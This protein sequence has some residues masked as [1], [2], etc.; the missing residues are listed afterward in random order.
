VGRWRSPWRRRGWRSPW[1]G[2]SQ[3]GRAPEPEQEPEQAMS[4]LLLGDGVLVKKYEG[5]GTY[6]KF[7]QGAVHLD[8]LN[9]VFS[10]FK[11]LGVVLMAAHSQG[12]YNIK[13]V[14]HT[15]FQFTTESISSWAVAEPWLRP[16]SAL[17]PPEPGIH[18][19]LFGT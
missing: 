1:R 9:H 2:R 8:Y 5:G 12:Q 18:Y 4:G 10:L 13:G 15:R 19:E 7:T 3:S 11:D 17:A 16:G 14:V 6:F